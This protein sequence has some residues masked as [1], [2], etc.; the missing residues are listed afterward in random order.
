[1]RQTSSKLPPNHTE[2]RK[3]RQ[4]TDDTCLHDEK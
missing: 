2:K 3:Y 1:M 4:L